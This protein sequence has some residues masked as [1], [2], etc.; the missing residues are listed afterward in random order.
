MRTRLMPLLLVTG[1]FA[2]P[3]QATFLDT[4]RES[5]S[6]K[7]R[8]GWSVA[9]AGDINGDGY[10]DIVVGAPGYSNGEAGE[11]AIYVYLGSASGIPANPSQIIEGGQV[12]AAFGASVSSA[13]DFNNDG[14]SD[15][16]VGAPGWTN[17]S[18]V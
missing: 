15:V 6:T 4:F 9:A 7:A 12:G 5:N 18:A 11:G 2:R 10:R 14:K 8:L 13:G 3:S 1:L 17:G 16:I